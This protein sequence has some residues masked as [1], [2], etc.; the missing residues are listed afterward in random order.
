MTQTLTR[1]AVLAMEAGPEMDAWVA[2]KV[3]GLEECFAGYP[4]Y[5]TDI[6]AAWEVVGKLLDKGWLVNTECGGPTPNLAIVYRQSAK[7][8]GCETHCG[9]GPIPLAICRAAL[10][11]TLEA[12]A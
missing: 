2:L 7:D 5:S 8:I 11:A 6:A 4:P 3:T 12:E 9:D 1:E 10:L